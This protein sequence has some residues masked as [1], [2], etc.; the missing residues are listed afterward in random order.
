VAAGLHPTIADA[1]GAM[2]SAHGVD[3]DPAPHAAFSDAY[4]RHRA[5]QRTL[6]D[7]TF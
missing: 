5:A 3:P 6:H 1:V 7:W 4:A 2:T